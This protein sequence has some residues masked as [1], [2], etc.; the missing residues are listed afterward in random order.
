MKKIIVLFFSVLITLAFIGCPMEIKKKKTD[1][2]DD[3]DKDKKEI[4]ALLVDDYWIEYDKYILN[5][6]YNTYTYI[7]RGGNSDV[8]NFT[9]TKINKCKQVTVYATKKFTAET[10]INAYSKDGYLYSIESLS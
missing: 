8:Y 6:S 10:I 2:D 9:E 1:I 4:D 5:N 3:K 7:I